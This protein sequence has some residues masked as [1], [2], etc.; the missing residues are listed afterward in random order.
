MKGKEMIKNWF[1]ILLSFL[2]VGVLSTTSARAVDLVI[3]H[4]ASPGGLTS[5]YATILAPQIEAKSDFKVKNKFIPGEGGWTSVR[6]Y[7]K[8]GPDSAIHVLIQNDKIS[9]SKYLTG[10]MSVDELSGLRPVALL[11]ESIYVLYAPKNL[12]V[13]KIADLDRLGLTAL[14]HG[15]IGPGSFGHLI[16][17]A[18]SQKIKTP[19]NSI[20]YQGGS[21][22][23]MTDIIGGHINL[24]SGWPDTLDSAKQGLT[25]VI[26]VSRPV[27]DLSGVE[28][29][30]KQGI[31]NVPTAAYWALFVG[32]NVSADQLKKLQD[33]MTKVFNDPAF[34]AE[35]ESKMNTTGPI[36][37]PKK[38]DSWWK[39]TESV[40]IQMSKD[41][42]FE[43][44]KSEVKAKR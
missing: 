21:G 8:Q 19:I 17:S 32:P 14:T 36:G 25:Q 44:F 39:E 29:F 5:R 40:Y 10:V 37:D 12:N 7:I 13:T 27:K 23:I 24:Y 28:T 41:P 11:G 1:K 6:Q 20:Y 3:W 42:G 9:L 43:K 35:W 16:E 15:S 4:G 38:L 34:V 22:K 30:A 31:T 18:L 33:V 2:T 26:A